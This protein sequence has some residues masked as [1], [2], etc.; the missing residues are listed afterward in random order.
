M[1]LHLADQHLHTD[2]SPDGSH[3]AILMCERAVELGLRAIAFTDHCEAPEYYD[4]Y[5]EKALPQAYFD[6]VKA[7]SVFQGRL[8]VLTGVELGGAVYEEE[9]CRRLLSQYSYDIVLSSLHFVKG[10]KEYHLIDYRQVDYR[11]VLEEYFKELLR[12]AKQ[13]L[14]DSLAHLDYPTRYIRM[15]GVACSLK[16]FADLIDEILKVLVQNGKALEINTSGLSACFHTTL[17][18]Y[19]VIKRFRDLGGE[20]VTVGSD[21]HCTASLGGGLEEGIALA[22]K[23]GFSYVTMFQRREPV[24]LK[25]E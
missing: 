20:L 5:Y 13:N 17:P 25:I 21:A 19:D 23:A 14:F 9:L 12:Q 3:S 2:N 18:G 7:K 15:Q 22:H 4:G 16:P 10:A 11:P 6:A 24:L 1:Y 8:L